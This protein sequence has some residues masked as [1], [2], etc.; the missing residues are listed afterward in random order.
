[1]TQLFT[2]KLWINADLESLPSYEESGNRYELIDGELFVTR[3]PHWKHQSVCGKVFSKLDRW[4]EQSKLGE[5]AIAP[6][7]IFNDTNNVIPDVVWASNQT[8]ASLD[9]GGHLTV[10]PELAIEVLS[11]GTENERRDRVT[12][13]KLFAQQGVQEYW[14]LDWQVERLE[15]YRLLD[16]NLEFVNTLSGSDR[17]ISSLLPNF[18]CRVEEF[19]K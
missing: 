3:A 9:K 10:A 7:I 11:T 12:K 13:L 17:I 4:S 6:G 5:V 2:K 1:M 16:N 14:I 19:F 8:M 15:I 18:S